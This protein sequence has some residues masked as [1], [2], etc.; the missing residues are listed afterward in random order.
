MALGHSTKIVTDGL[1]FYYDQ[2]NIQKSWKGMPLT[3][4]IS[5]VQSLYTY[6]N[7]SGTAVWTNDDKTVA[8]LFSDVQVNSMYKDT[9]GNSMVAIGY[10]PLVN[11]ATHTVSCYAYIPTN[12]GTLAGTVPY[13]R[14]FPANTSRGTLT[15]NG[16]SDW[17][18]W[19]RDQWIRISATWTN[20]AADTYMYISC[21]LDNAGN[22]IYLTAPQGEQNSFAT[23]FVNGTRSNSQSILDLT[24]NE[25]VTA[26]SATYNSDGTFSF[27]GTSNYINTSVIGSYSSYTI[28]MWCKINGTTGTQQR[29][30]SSTSG[31]THCINTTPPGQFGFHYNPLDGSPSSTG[32]YTGVNVEYN[33]WYHIVATNDSTNSVSGAKI[34][35]NGE[36]KGSQEPA[37][38]LN[39]NVYFGSDRTVSL[40]SNSTISIGK[41]YNRAL[42][43]A[44][45]QQ[46]FNAIR[47]RYPGHSVNNPAIS[48]AQIREADP[49]ASNGYYWINPLGYTGT[50]EYV[51]VD[52]D[53]SVS[54]ITDAGPWVRIRYAQDYYSQAAPW[55]SSGISSTTPGAYSGDFA[56]EQNYNWIDALLARSTET[57]QRFES[58]GYGSV[59]WTYGNGEYMGVKTFNGFSYNGENSSNIVKLNKPAGISHGVTDFNTFNNP[60]ASGTD[61]TDANDSVWR[62]GVFYF[63]DTSGNKILPIRGIYNGD[64]D[65]APEQRYF[66]FRNGTA[67]AGVNSDI[68]VK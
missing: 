4:G 21:Y 52:F 13:F 34:Y 61:P 62:V 49:T 20:T 43:A 46:N 38:A 66:P 26:S 29:I 65:T 57:R 47:V 28:E 53:G 10:Y 60:T 5:N 6:W 54:G 30:F 19:P 18:T 51:Y 27:N 16:I 12:A 23:P 24:G 45:V 44:E 17:N 3:N 63:R 33:T 68:W 67:S 25:T 32:A 36:L 48:A 31:G 8:R 41:I 42:T 64:V 58:W 55:S 39:G 15:Y 22:K 2:N 37:I 1:V 7:N 56:F 11:G 9:A 14:S 50:P 40:F 59:G 35:L